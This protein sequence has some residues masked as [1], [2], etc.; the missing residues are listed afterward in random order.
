MHP[1]W[2]KEKEGV[3]EE[4]SFA[5]ARSIADLNCCC[6]VRPSSLAP[7]LGSGRSKGFFP[8]YSGFHYVPTKM[9]LPQSLDMLLI[10]LAQSCIRPARL[11]RPGG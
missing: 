2:T 1:S 4:R 6:G 9:Y 8:L 5:A 3:A 10:G 7:L 11:P